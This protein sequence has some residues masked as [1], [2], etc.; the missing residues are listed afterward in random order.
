MV[1]AYILVKISTQKEVYGFNRS[2]VKK[3]CSMKGVENAELLFGDYDAI[4]KLNAP[5]I[6]DIEN[7]VMEGISMI[8]GV[9][10]TVTLLCVDEQILE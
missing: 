3:I 2:V 5:K 1:E 4:V 9:E 8:E 7:L 10:S 6:H